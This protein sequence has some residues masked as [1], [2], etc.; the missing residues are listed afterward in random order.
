MLKERESLEQKIKY[1]KKK[2]KKGQF[3]EKAFVVKSEFNTNMTTVER[4]QYARPWL[5]PEIG[6]AG[7]IR[8]IMLRTRAN[9]YC[10]EAWFQNFG[11]MMENGQVELSIDELTNALK[12]LKLKWADD[13]ILVEDVFRNLDHNQ[14]EEMK[15]TVDLNELAMAVI[16]CASHPCSHYEIEYL[17]VCYN[18]L[19]R[20][21]TLYN[22]KDMM[23][24]LNFHR[25]YSLT[26]DEFLTVFRKNLDID[27][28][29]LED[30]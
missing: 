23:A 21:E 12:A 9:G 22:M 5:H 24:F 27:Q 28:T 20:Q 25:D 29:E 16:D 13:K 1:V 26:A 19:K 15:G 14:D 17:E 18:I 3:K 6:L 30:W 11:S 4:A 2:A 8:D 10:V 7:E